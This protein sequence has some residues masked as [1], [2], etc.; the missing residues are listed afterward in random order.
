MIFTNL[1]EIVDY[2]D[3]IAAL[4]NK[5]PKIVGL[6]I[7]DPDVD[8]VNNDIDLLDKQIFNYNFIPNINTDSLSYITIDTVVSK[9]NNDTTKTL[10]IIIAVISSKTNMKLDSLIFKGVRGNRRDN[11]IR[12]IDLIVRKMNNLGIGKVQLTSRTPVSPISI[13]STD[14]TAKQLVYEMPNFDRLVK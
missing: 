3:A 14:Y 10:N 13:G 5:D 6:L 4:L 7:D 11:L 9:V 2:P 1:D 8:P 12:Y